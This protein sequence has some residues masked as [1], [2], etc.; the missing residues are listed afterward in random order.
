[1]FLVEHLAKPM[2]KTAK[3]KRMRG[4]IM[5]LLFELSSSERDGEYQSDNYVIENF[6]V[7]NMAPKRWG[8]RRL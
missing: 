7:L 6:L 1:M 5:S 4:N 8:G 3:E 2:R